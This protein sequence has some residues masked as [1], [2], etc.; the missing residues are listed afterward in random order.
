MTIKE[1]LHH[2][3]SL[4]A[5][6]RYSSEFQEYRVNVPNGT[7][8]TAYYTSDGAD[9]IGTARHML[10]SAASEQP[11]ELD[12]EEVRTGWQEDPTNAVSPWEAE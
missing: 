3:R 10:G 1:T 12:I 7:E 11:Q 2:I 5:V 8:A 6:A 9:A 4:G